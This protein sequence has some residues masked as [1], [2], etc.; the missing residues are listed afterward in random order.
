M[1]TTK[2]ATVFALALAMSFGVQAAESVLKTEDVGVKVPV[3][4]VEPAQVT[5][6]VAF[7]G[8]NVFV[9]ATEQVV[10]DTVMVTPEMATSAKQF[11]IVQ[12]MLPKITSVGQAANNGESEASGT[13][14]TKL[15]MMEPV[16]AMKTVVN[17]VYFKYGNDVYSYE[18]T[19]AV[20]D[21]VTLT[22]ELIAMATKE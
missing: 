11:N 20:G 2:I 21:S 19:N 12:D 9:M 3:E 17:K 1:K 15:G 7:D 18:T 14:F 22:H 8:H 10:E 4:F 16:S 5:Q 13:P 6:V